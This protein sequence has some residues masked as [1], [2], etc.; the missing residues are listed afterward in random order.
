MKRIA[1]ADLVFR[2]F[3]LLD[4]EWAILVAGVEKPN[5]MTVSWGSFGTLWNRPVVTVFVRPT[6]FTY[7]PMNAHPEFTVNILPP[8]MREALDLCGST[9]GRNTDKWAEGGLRPEPSEAVVVPGVAGSDLILE[10][11]TLH[12]FDLDPGRF[13]DSAIEGLYPNKDYHRAFVGEVLASRASERFAASA[14]GRSEVH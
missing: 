1:P 4:H 12:T 10:C 2:P 7:G 14:P 3:H 8:T 9:S 11:R 5:P 13:L 6:R